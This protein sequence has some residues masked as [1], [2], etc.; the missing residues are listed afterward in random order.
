MLRPLMV[1]KCIVKVSVLSHFPY[2]GN[3][4]YIGII[5]YIGIC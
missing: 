1:N 4:M 3:R 2:I 5:M